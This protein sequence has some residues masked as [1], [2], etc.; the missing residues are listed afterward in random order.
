MLNP[1][2]PELAMMLHR[3][4]VNESLVGSA[5]E[6]QAAGPPPQ[7]P[8]PR[9]EVAYGVNRT[10]KPALPSETGRPSSRRP[11]FVFGPT[12]S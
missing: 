9:P 3:E 5:L 7:S 10:T 11:V 6:R 1:V 2:R 12:H 8:P 4:R